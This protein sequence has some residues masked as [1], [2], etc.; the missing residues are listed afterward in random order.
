VSPAPR[1]DRHADVVSDRPYPARAGKLARH[2]DE[3]TPAW[4][5][6]MLRYRY[7]GVT[8]RDFEVLEVQSTHTTKLRLALDL[9]EGGRAAG[10]PERVCLKSNW[11]DGIKTGDICEREARFY[12]LAGGQL[13]APLPR[14]YYADWDGDGGG[15]GLVV[16]EDLATAGGRFGHSEDHLGVDGVAAG[17]ESLA[18]LH[19]ALW[20]RPELDDARMLPRSMDT[21]TDTE[22][23]V[24][25][26]NYLALNLEDPVYQAVLPAWAYEQP[27]RLNHLLDELG[28]YERARPGPFGLVHGDAH[29]GNSYVRPDGSRIWV[30]FQLARAGTPWRD[31]NYFMVGALTV[32]ERRAHE[33]ELLDL[34]RRA[35]V[36][37]GAEG[38]PDLDA[39]WEDLRRWTAYGMQCWLGNVDRWGQAGVEIVRR[40]F[41]A[42]D[43]HGTVDLL[44]AGKA[45]RRQVTLGEEASRLPPDLQALRDSRTT[46]RVGN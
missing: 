7:P 40:F 16:M 20:G 43:D 34:Y 28:A 30:D 33:R 11:S 44:V 1:P 36:A 39:A 42:G 45:P 18:R 21:A 31:V 2:L 37:T 26:W 23:V 32:E 27:E 3:V 12:H 10:L 14:T 15:R 5:T 8:V 4:L 6:T 41:T 17:L 22:Q 19:G 35:L 24:R 25:L 38:V 13:D 29:Q 9:D 46:P